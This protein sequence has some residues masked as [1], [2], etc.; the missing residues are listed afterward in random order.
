MHL[1]FTLLRLIAKEIRLS[2]IALYVDS[3]HTSP[4]AMSV[5]LT[6][7]EKGLPFELYTVDLGRG[8]NLAGAYADMSLTRK[9]PLLIHDGFHLTESSAITE[10][11]E[12][13]FAPPNHAAVYPADPKKKARARQVQAWIRSDLMPIRAERSTEVIFMGKHFGPLSDAAQQAKDKLV[14][15]AD[16]LIEHGQNNLFG[17][18]S[19]ADADLAVMLN[20][21]VM[22]GDAMPEKLVAYAQQQWQRPSIQEW[23]ALAR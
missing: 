12:D 22:H 13:H 8:E 20:R 21:L 10:Y 18:W 23:V 15:A 5:Y 6:L 14:A 4:Y 11:L 2:K 7:K 9:V 16:R 19:I 17:E 1:C 3:L